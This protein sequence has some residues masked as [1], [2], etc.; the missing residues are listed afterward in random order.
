MIGPGNG[1]HARKLELVNGRKQQNNTA[2]APARSRC[3]RA[4]SAATASAAPNA[5][6][7]KRKKANR[8]RNE[9]HQRPPADKAEAPSLN[10]KRRPRH[11]PHRRPPPQHQPCNQRQRHRPLRRHRRRQRTRQKRCR[12]S[13]ESSRVQPAAA[14]LA[15]RQ[16]RRSHRSLGGDSSMSNR[17]RRPLARLVCRP[18]R[19]RVR[20]HRIRLCEMR[21]VVF[22]VV[23]RKI[24]A[25]PQPR[26]RCRP[27][28]NGA[29]QAV[30]AR[31]LCSGRSAR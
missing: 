14:L 4:P 11:R 15:Q 17:R 19:R 25:E 27:E 10:A 30:L 28:R 8:R 13:A 26:S 2:P 22:V 9:E 31:D 6:P 21:Q 20:R 7:T 24:D 23:C 16:P 5:A 29:L 12:I 1:L 18:S 3:E